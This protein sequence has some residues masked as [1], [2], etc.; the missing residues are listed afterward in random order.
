[1]LCTAMSNAAASA[2]PYRKH[3]PELWGKSPFGLPES[4]VTIPHYDSFQCRHSGYL[5]Y[6]AC[7]MAY[8][9][10]D[11]NRIYD[12]ML[13]EKTAINNTRRFVRSC[14]LTQERSGKH[15]CRGK[16]EALDICVCVC[17]CVRAHVDEGVSAYVC[18]CV[19]VC[20]WASA[21]A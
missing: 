10:W 5:A 3:Y 2:E 21:G 11:K 18:V 16:Q 20:V 9:M 4:V 12:V 1:M 13:L 7:V 19:C 8:R 15:C 14:N 17:A 6:K